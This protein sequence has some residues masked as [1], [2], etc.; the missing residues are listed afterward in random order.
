MSQPEQLRNFITDQTGRRP[1][2]VVDPSKVEGYD[3]SDQPEGRSLR[4]RMRD[5]GVRLDLI[6][7]P[8]VTVDG[9]RPIGDGMF[10]GQVNGFNCVT[11]PDS[12]CAVVVI[13]DR[14]VE[15]LKNFAQALYR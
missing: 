8:N 9:V 1:K 12:G 13:G 11:W 15:G 6:I 14:D 5:S 10:A 3:F 4:V 2:I 7:I